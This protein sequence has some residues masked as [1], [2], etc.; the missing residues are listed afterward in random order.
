MAEQDKIAEALLNNET[1]DPFRIGESFEPAEAAGAINAVLQTAPLASAGSQPEPGF[2]EQ[3]KVEKDSKGNLFESKAPKSTEP[4]W[5]MAEAV[6]ITET[7]MVGDLL[8]DQEAQDKE[9]FVFLTQA[10]A[11]MGVVSDNLDELARHIEA[12]SVGEDPTGE[13]AG[14]HGRQLD[15]RRRWTIPSR[16]LSG[17]LPS[18]FPAGGC[19]CPSGAGSPP[20]QSTRH[21][22]KRQQEVVQFLDANS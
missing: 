5:E 22:Q 18:C 14:A 4:D 17:A 9:Q 1:Y 8:Q 21:L 16:L 10:D 7:D 19:W 12:F 13:L 11:D 3:L 6:P 15:R 20:W 2:E